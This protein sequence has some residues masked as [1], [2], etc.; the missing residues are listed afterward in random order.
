MC[1]KIKCDKHYGG[2]GT[3]LPGTHQVSNVEISRMEQNWSRREQ[4]EL[5]GRGERDP[6]PLKNWGKFNT[7][8]AAGGREVVLGETGEG[9]L[10]HGEPYET[11]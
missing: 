10:A 8:G 4:R 5:G 6:R 9:G 11:G 2:G 1:I 7:A 3:L